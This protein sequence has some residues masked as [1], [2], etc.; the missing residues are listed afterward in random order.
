MIPDTI[1]GVSVRC[2]PVPTDHHNSE[3]TAEQYPLSP[4]G[5]QCLV[6]TLQTMK[7]ERDEN[8]AHFSN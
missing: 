5:A 1:S 6:W 2:L 3:E 4:V 8:P 7:A